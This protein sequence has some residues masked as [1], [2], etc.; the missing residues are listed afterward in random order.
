MTHT[1]PPSDHQ[2]PTA[3]V[4]V[5]AHAGHDCHCEQHLPSHLR[6]SL[7]KGLLAA[8]LAVPLAAGPCA[9]AFAASAAATSTAVPGSIQDASVHKNLWQQLIDRTPAAADLVE[10]IDSFSLGPA[11][12]PW[13]RQLG[14]VRAGQQV[15]FFLDGLWWFSEE[16]GRWLAPG[17]VFFSRISGADGNS[18]I[19]NAMQNTATFKADRSG[20]L[21]L[22]RSVGEFGGPDGQLWVPEEVYRAG[23]GN[24]QGVAIVWQDD[25]LKGLLALS[26][27]A[28]SQ[29]GNIQGQIEAEL[30]HLRWQE[31]V[32]V[33]WHNFF[34]FGDGNIFTE[35]PITPAKNNLSSG[36]TTHIAID[37]WTHKNVGILQYPLADQALQPGLM[38]NWQWQVDHL[39]S[40]QP[41]DQLL[42][43]DY[44]SIAV[45]FDDGQDLTYFWSSSLPVG[46]VFRCPIPGW[47][48]VETHVVQRSGKQQLGLLLDEQ[49]DVYKDYQKI[50]GGNA[51]RV[52]QVWLI[53]NSLF[54]RGFGR[55]A[56]G[57]IV[58]GQ[59]GQQQTVL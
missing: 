10:R 35:M 55:C 28:Q 22:A 40:E 52:V 50:I 39:P 5:T 57:R 9:S 51:S 21:Q 17:F 44:L 23:R 33:G 32:P 27:Q 43:H 11:D 54:N 6:R 14:N 1:L 2:Y 26:Q 31:R 49:R 19:W 53:A 59:P 3:A 56:F 46:K 58:I 13:Q 15:S 38:L 20:Q 16:A 8:P 18:H 37:C 34:A 48:Q 36:I 12:M 24:I 41:E 29:Q 7:M 42:N 47:D 25:A 30:N 45:Q 4:S